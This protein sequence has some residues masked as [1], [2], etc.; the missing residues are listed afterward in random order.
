MPKIVT[1]P[2]GRIPCPFKVVVDTR[3]QTP[4]EF[5]QVRANAKLGGLLYEVQTVRRALATGDY[6]IDGMPRFA[7]ERKS[8]ADLFGSMARRENFLSRLARFRAT[9]DV[10]VV[11]IEAEISTILASP[12]RFSSMPVKSVI[13]SIQSWTVRYPTVHW[14]F[15]PGR[16]A[17]ERWTFSLLRLYYEA[18]SAEASHG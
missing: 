11:V 1:R 17:A 15:L 8:M 3:E 16:D 14:H 10:A 9:C 5:K 18:H 7:V 4:Y 6:A 13:R 12:P 2:D